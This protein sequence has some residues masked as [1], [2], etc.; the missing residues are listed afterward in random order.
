M[1]SP[2]TKQKAAIW[3]ILVFALGAAVGAVFGYSFARKSYA[4]TTVAAPNLSE[5]E[6][7]T[8][9]VAEIKN[10]VG[11]TDEQAQKMDAI[12]QAGHIQM[13]AIREKADADS[14]GVRARAREQMRALLTEEQKP[15]FEEM[16]QKYDEER[17]KK[18]AEE[19]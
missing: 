6:R 12:M 13:K 18:K 9:K 4:S 2:E 3:L 5:T 7:R 14:D 19:K 10:T 15:K 1:M 17:K 11:L 16:V 8:K